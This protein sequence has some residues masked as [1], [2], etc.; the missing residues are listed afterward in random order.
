M[1]ASLRSSRDRSGAAAELMPRRIA[2]L[3]RDPNPPDDGAALQIVPLEAARAF[4][5]ELVAEREGIVIVHQDESFAGNQGIE[6]PEDRG[7][8]LPRGDHAYVE[9]IRISS[10][11]LHRAISIEGA[12]HRAFRVHDA[13]AGASPDE[14][15]D[16]MLALLADLVLEAELVEAGKQ[17][18]RH[19][20][21]Q[22]DEGRPG[23]ERLE[24]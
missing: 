1:H 11:V 17:E 5:L 10:G 7:M 9:L 16:Q 24:G 13:S 8:L 21:V 12:P 14:E 23:G 2:L 22:L 20:Y 18:L 6:G 4:R 19:P 3:L 15:A